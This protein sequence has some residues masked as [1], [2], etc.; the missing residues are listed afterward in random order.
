MAAPAVSERVAS[1]VVLLLERHRVALRVH[2]V[3]SH[4][5]LLER[6]LD[7][8]DLPAAE[9][10]RVV[11]LLPGREVEGHAGPLL[12]DLRQLLLDD[13]LLVRGLTNVIDVVR[14]LVEVGVDQ[15]SAA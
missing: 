4:H 8:D 9:A 3:E 12:T 5:G 10:A 2:R 15:G 6:L 13:Q 11:A 7:L 1:I 14:K